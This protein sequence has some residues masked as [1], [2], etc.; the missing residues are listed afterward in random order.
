MTGNQAYENKYLQLIDTLITTNPDKPYLSGYRYFLSD[1]AVASIYRYSTH[2][3]TFMDQTKKEVELLTLDDYVIFL[4]KIKSLS[5]SY[6]I[7]VYTALKKFSKYL[8]AADRN[9]KNPMQ[10]VNRPKFK[11]SK[12]TQEKRDKGYLAK[13]EIKTYLSAVE[14]GVGSRHAKALQEDWRERDLCIIMLLLNTGMRRSALFKLD[15]DSVDLEK[16]VLTTVDKGGRVQVYDLSSDMVSC[17]EEWLEKRGQLADDNEPALF[18]S[19]KMRR[20]STDGIAQIVNKYGVVVKGKNITPHKLRAT[21]GTQLYAQT[22][23]IYFV[24]QCMDHA[25]PRTTT[26]YIRGQKSD[27]RK[28]AAAIMKE[29]TS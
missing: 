9:N 15:V 17:L 24:Q 14:N 2:V 5:S 13:K 19:R 10:H 21:Y 26:M 8:Q 6:Q 22:H 3:A 27:S 16:Q 1:L 7:Q 11:E 29:L 20:L 25:N 18:I 12:E 23:D 28:R 4:G